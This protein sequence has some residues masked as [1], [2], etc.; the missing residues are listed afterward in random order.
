MMNRIMQ[1]RLLIWFDANKRSFNFRQNRNAYRVWVAEVML[2]QTRAQVV[3]GYFERF[4]NKW[5]TIHDLCL[6]TENEV[7]KAFEGLGYYSRAKRL[8]AGAKEIVKNYDGQIPK[9]RKELLGIVGIGEYTAG[10]ILSF[11]YRQ[12]QVAVDGNVKRVIARLVGYQ[13]VLKGQGVMKLLSCETQK[14]I[15]HERGCDIME[16]L[17][18]LGATVCNKKAVCDQCP[19]NKNC[20]AYKKKL[21]D[22]IPLMPE[23][24]KNN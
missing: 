4:M 13:S 1:E 16:S 15:E 8:L 18:E 23:R 10:A 17:I 12:T 2:Q 11:A 19:L 3:E 5:P 21:T 20:L 6:A 7:L 14:F 9:T 24:K 22:V